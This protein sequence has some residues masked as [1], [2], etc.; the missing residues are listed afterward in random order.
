MG[1]RH[2]P[3]SPDCFALDTHTFCL[4]LRCA[5]GDVREA[6]VIYANKYDWTIDRHTREMT[7]AFADAQYDYYVLT[8]RVEDTR[9]A[10]IFHLE[11]A[12]GE[13]R[14]YSE[15]GLSETYDF[16]YGYLTF[17]QYPYINACDVVRPVE[18]VRRSTVYQIFVE[19][20][21]M[22]NAEKACEYIN[23]DWNDIPTPKSFAGGDLAGITAKLP[24]L[25]EMGFGCIYLTP[26]FTAPSNHKY[27][28]VDYTQVDP[29][30]GG[31]EA[32][33][34]LV[35]AAHAMNIKVVLDAVF[36]HVSW[37]F[38]PFQD[39]VRNGK[40]SPYY[41]W[42]MI[43]GD[44]VDLETPNYERFGH[45]PYMPKLNTCNPAV[46]AYL[47]DIAGMWTRDYHIDGWRL[48]VSD[49]VSHTF[50]RAF[51]R[52]IKAISPDVYITGENW[53]D[54]GPWLRGDEFDGIMNYAFTKAAMDYFVSEAIDATGL[55][56]RLTGL[57]MRYSDTT[58]AM[59]L[60]LLDSHDTHRFLSLL[61]GNVARLRCA[62][63]LLYCYVGTPMVYYG[64][65][66]GLLGGYD[67]DCRRP[68]PWDETKWEA[69][70]PELIRRLNGYRTLPV[71][72]EGD[73]RLRAEQDVFILYRTYEAQTMTLLVNLSGAERVVRLADGREM[74]LPHEDFLI[75]DETQAMTIEPITKEA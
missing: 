71:L 8:L 68:F 39:V 15:A 41:D 19:R 49:E 51:R 2:V 47:L 9:M 44:T 30:F 4:R 22:G 60:N 58:N 23:L 55:C 31:N 28:T 27:D 57:L 16:D 12:D 29:M 72:Q 75:L 52:H 40:D 10:Y 26:V 14:Y 70:L 42:F 5:R 38:A 36:N 53:H 69:T 11:G 65:E 33:R 32:L 59:L 62:L 20:F 1:L 61:G 24:Y 6:T 45:V 13:R 64:T 25:R 46:E 17:F 48:D 63:A 66:V 21:L 37:H 18:W 74:H 43:D 50:W 73:I 54:A 67:P 56:D 7:L 3:Q 34:Q 35:E